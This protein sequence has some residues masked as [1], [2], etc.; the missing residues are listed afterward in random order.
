MGGHLRLHHDLLD[1]AGS[2]NLAGDGFHDGLLARFLLS[3]PND[4]FLH[5]G[6]SLSYKFLDGPLFTL[7]DDLFFS[8]LL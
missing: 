7:F 6:L 1:H 3:F 2:L 5:L 8:D 4:S